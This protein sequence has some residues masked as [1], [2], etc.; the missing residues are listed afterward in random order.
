MAQKPLLVQVREI[1]LRY[2]ILPQA[3]IIPDP[4]SQY[5]LEDMLQNTD[6]RNAFVPKEGFD[7]DSEIETY[8]LRIHIQADRTP[9]QAWMLS[10]H[11]LIDYAELYY[12]DA[13]GNY[14][15]R[16]AGSL[17]P[18]QE[19]ERNLIPS[20]FRDFMHLHLS[21]SKQTFYLKISSPT[22][23]SRQFRAGERFFEL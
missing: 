4:D 23:L 1:P 10:I 15:K 11:K 6:I 13:K 9:E 20:N 22:L 17:V 12:P 3:E 16:K 7:Y 19:R 14:Q 18:P 21:E 2:A 5:Q 8:W